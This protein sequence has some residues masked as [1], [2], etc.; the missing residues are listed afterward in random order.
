MPRKDVISIRKNVK[1][2]KLAHQELDGCSVRQTRASDV[3]K[4]C[5]QQHQQQ[6]HIKLPEINKSGQLLN[7]TTQPNQQNQ[8]SSKK[9]RAK[10]KSCTDLVFS[11][12]PKASA[13]VRTDVI[14]DCDAMTSPR[15]SE[16]THAKRQAF[17]KKVVI[18]A[19]LVA[20]RYIKTVDHTHDVTSRVGRMSTM[21]MTSS[22]MSAKSQLMQP[23]MMYLVS[24]VNDSCMPL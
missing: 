15:C 11:G 4:R 14:K 17:K 5:K 24:T 12:L 2:G 20:K 16:A 7:K 6:Q 19:R 10:S 22:Q 18:L 21:P 9:S 8:D 23:L 13:P 3:T 1:L